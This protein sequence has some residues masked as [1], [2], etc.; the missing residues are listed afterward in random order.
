MA[1]TD[2]AEA[3][4][5]RADARRQRRTD[6]NDGAEQAEEA[7]FSGAGDGGSEDDSHAGLKHAAKVA[8]A[9]AAIGAAVG[10][11][12]SGRDAPSEDGD[13]EPRSDDATDRDDEDTPEA[14]VRQEEPVQQEQDEEDSPPTDEVERTLD[15]AAGD[16]PTAPQEARA[17][18]RDSG[19]PQK[20]APPDETVEVASRA[21]QQLQA[22]HGREPESVSSLARTAEG[23]TVT[24]EVVELQRVPDSTDVIASYEL[25][26]DEDKNLIRY[27]RRRRY[28][29]SQADRGDER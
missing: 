4:R 21:R 10:A 27:E 15:D 11:A 7:E 3:Q 12:L 22:L 19:A 16:E 24:V 25:L 29:R 1:D 18:D 9:G 23:W 17:G 14:A 20:G 13:D 2:R 28:Y 8:A 26:L 6:G 5:R